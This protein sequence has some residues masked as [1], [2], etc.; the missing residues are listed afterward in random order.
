MADHAS[1]VGDICRYNDFTRADEICTILKSYRP[2]YPGDESRISEAQWAEM[3]QELL[4]LEKDLADTKA[5]LQRF[6][7]AITACSI[8]LESSSSESEDEAGTDWPRLTFRTSLTFD[9]NES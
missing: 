7:R 9:F 8:D 3:T 4:N 5:L 6:Y 1:K 2:D